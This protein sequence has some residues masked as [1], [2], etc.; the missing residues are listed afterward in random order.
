MRYDAAPMSLAIKLISAA[1]I[2]LDAGFAAAAF[3]HIELL[4]AVAAL[5]LVLIG[6]YLR[7][8]V[9]Y[10]VS[11]SG[12]VVEFRIG[13]KEFGRVIGQVPVEPCTGMTL[14]LWGN[15]G[16]FAGTG[17]FW[18]RTWGLFRAYVT[19]SDRT[20]LVLLETEKGKV[21]V[22]PNHPNQFLSSAAAGSK[23]V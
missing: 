12:L 5:T 18:N 17:I 3:W 21:L 2:L 1:V 23:S 20:R 15:G 13:T 9:A 6:C 16:L 4:L 22:T 11:K 10:H 19:T 7:A 14:R 8:P